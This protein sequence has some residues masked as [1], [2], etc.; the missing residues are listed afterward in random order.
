MGKPQSKA[1]CAGQSPPSPPASQPLLFPLE[2]APSEGKKKEKPGKPQKR[3]RRQEL[4]PEAS[5][6]PSTPDCMAACRAR[7]H[8]R[9]CLQGVPR[10][11]V[12]GEGNQ[13][14]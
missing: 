8:D 10:G 7:T 2:R 11:A 12:V 9:H 4:Q 5:S 14:P 3:E 1:E 6:L 13:L